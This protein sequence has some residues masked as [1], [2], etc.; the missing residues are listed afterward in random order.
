MN[1]KLIISLFM[2]ILMVSIIVTPILAADIPKGLTQLNK[3][4]L[5]GIRGMGQNF[6]IEQID[7][8]NVKFRYSGNKG[9]AFK[10]ASGVM[11][12]T[13]VSGNKNTINNVVN[14]KI[15]I[16]NID[17]VESLNLSDIKNMINIK[18]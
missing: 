9:N 11:N 6:S 10:H 4:E 17:Q 12:I 5:S 18:D 14:L 2:T 16:Y 3:E 1:K 13:N 15:N 8:S 7:S